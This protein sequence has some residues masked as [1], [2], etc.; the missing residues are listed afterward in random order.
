MST[1]DP[2]MRVSNAERE[3]II[4]R[5]HAA[6]E[7]GRLELDEFAERS[8]DAYAAKTYAELERLLKDL[9]ETDGVLVVP[10]GVSPAARR[11]TESPAELHLTPKASSM[12]RKGEWLVPRRI[13]IDGKASSVKL[14]FTSA[15]IGTREV[16]VELDATASSVEL[17]LPDGAYAEEQLDLIASSAKNRCEY[18][19]VNGLRFEVAGKAKASSVKIR[20]QYRFLWWRW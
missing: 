19:G 10:E 9:P 5:L 2:N 16:T 11:A 15:V 1:P 17:I 6:T 14:D 8:R 7:E 20:Y 12:Q 4:A 3:A 13:R 18:R